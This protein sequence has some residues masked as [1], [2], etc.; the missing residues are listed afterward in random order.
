MLR[1]NHAQKAN[2][3]TLQ[4]TQCGKSITRNQG[5][6]KQIKNAF[7]S[8]SCAATYNNTHKTTGS[9]RSKLEIWLETKL[10]VLYPSLE[11]LYCDKQIINAELD[12]YVPSLK[13]AFE[14]NGIYHYEPIHGEDKLKQ[15]KT[16]DSRKYQTCIEHGI[17]LVIMD[18]SSLKYFKE[19]NCQ[20]YLN[21]MQNI[22]NIKNTRV[23]LE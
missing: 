4:C 6:L 15:I 13:L 3:V 10:S 17:E 1:L 23:F 22:I 2:T 19:R 16:N 20:K 21:I 5:W 7:C 12:I 14:L 18:V 11:I 9:R 8:Q